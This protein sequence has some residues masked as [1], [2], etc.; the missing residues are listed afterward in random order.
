MAC[1][2][3]RGGNPVKDSTKTYH[4]KPSLNDVEDSYEKSK[5]KYRQYDVMQRSGRV[6]TE[7]E[8]D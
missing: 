7:E 5:L 3:R 2:G 8:E 1:S 4:D 6:R